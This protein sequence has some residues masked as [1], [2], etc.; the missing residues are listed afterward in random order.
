MEAVNQNTYSLIFVRDQTSDICLA[1]VK[2]NKYAIIYVRD[3]TK[4]I[5]SQAAK[6]DSSV[7]EPIKQ[8]DMNREILRLLLVLLVTQAL[9]ALALVSIM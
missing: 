4:E 5:Y 9:Q 2:R 1:A 7:T 3:K 8:K 6:E